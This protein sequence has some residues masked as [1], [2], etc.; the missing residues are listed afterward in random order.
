MVGTA[1]Q[2]RVSVVR[3]TAWRSGTNEFLFLFSMARIR[4]QRR[5]RGDALASK[6]PLLCSHTWRDPGSTWSKLAMSG[7]QSRA[8]LSKCLAILGLG[9]R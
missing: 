8:P 7:Q 1:A 3:T 6:Q 4:L 9:N 5:R 2:G